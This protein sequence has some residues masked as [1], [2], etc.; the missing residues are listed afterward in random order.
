[1]QGIDLSQNGFL[2][3]C[4]SLLR[5]DSLLLCGIIFKCVLLNSEAGQLGGE[6][7]PVF[8]VAHSKDNGVEAGGYLG[9]KSRDLREERSDGALVSNDS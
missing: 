6:G 2:R 8:G 3:Q 4:L 9:N 5:L 1:M 7:F